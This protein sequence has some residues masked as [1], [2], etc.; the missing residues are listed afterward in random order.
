M[1]KAYLNWSSGKDAALALY[2]LQQE[3][4]FSVEKLVTT[5][6]TD[7]NRI[8][9]HGI[10]A[11]LLTKQAENIVLPLHQIKL[12][13]E[14]S[15]AQYTEVMEMETNKLLKEGFT[16]SVFGDIFLEDLK[17][18]REKHL[19]EIGL[20]AV[21]PLWKENTKNL[22]EEFINLGFKAIVVCVNAN[23]LD[24]SFCGRILDQNFLNDLPKDVDPCGENGEFHT[25]VSDGPIFKEPI[26][27]KIGEMVERSYKP[28]KESEDNCFSDDQKS[29]D[30]NFVYCDLLLE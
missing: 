14:I 1:K 15:M 12:D 21:F 3:N 11:D 25:F 7:F 27:F 29:W 8:S 20:Q 19:E 30:T 17:R 23:K 5:V 16:H 2:K 22:L 26:N 6:N 13:G 24:S 9:M 10:R 4:E 18:Y 28:A